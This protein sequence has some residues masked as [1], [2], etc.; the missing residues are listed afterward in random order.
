M[1]ADMPVGSPGALGA[2]A[3]LPARE[4]RRMANPSCL[5]VLSPRQLNSSLWGKD[6]LAP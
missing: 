2:P 5:S 6:W 1:P 3:V 4:G